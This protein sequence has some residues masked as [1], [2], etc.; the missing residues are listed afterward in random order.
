MEMTVK[1]DGLGR[2][3]DSRAEVYRV[4]PIQPCIIQ[5]RGGYVQNHKGTHR[6]LPAST[7]YSTQVGNDATTDCVSPWRG[8]TRGNGMEEVLVG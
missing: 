5:R 7:I 1:S 8:T 4:Q 3:S 6:R 2:R